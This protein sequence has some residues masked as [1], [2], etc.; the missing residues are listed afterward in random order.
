MSGIVFL[1]FVFYVP[2]PSFALWIIDSR[3][4]SPATM[5]SNVPTARDCSENNTQPLA[6]SFFESATY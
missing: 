6:S 4:M 2:K 1:L 5:S 3:V